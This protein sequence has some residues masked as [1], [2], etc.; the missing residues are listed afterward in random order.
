VLNM[1]EHC[2]SEELGWLHTKGAID[3][4]D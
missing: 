4:L 1:A 2:D 3:L